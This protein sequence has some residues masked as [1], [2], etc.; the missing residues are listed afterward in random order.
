MLIREEKTIAKITPIK[1]MVATY[2]ENPAR[3]ENAVYCAFHYANKYNQNYYVFSYNLY[4]VKTFI[5]A[6]ESDLEKYIFQDSKGL[7]V[8]Y[9]DGTVKQAFFEKSTLDK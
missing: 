9:P 6:S 8:V 3:F 2:K 1:R 4:M 5:I 7:A